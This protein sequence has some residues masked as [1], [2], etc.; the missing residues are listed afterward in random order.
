M[1]A[2]TIQSDRGIA[3]QGQLTYGRGGVQNGSFNKRVAMGN[4]FGNLAGELFIDVDGVSRLRM[5]PN[6]ALTVRGTLYTLSNVTGTVQQTAAGV[7]DHTFTTNAVGVTTI[8][9]NV[10]AVGFTV[11][12]TNIPNNIGGTEDVLNIVL[13]APGINTRGYLDAAIVDQSQVAGAAQTRQVASAA[14]VQSGRY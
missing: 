10:A 5:P 1:A 4:T 9:A 12:K 6:T 11:G 13:S 2:V 3:L 7:F 14:L 8:L